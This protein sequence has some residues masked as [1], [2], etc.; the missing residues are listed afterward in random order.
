M[1]DVLTIEQY[2]SFTLAGE[3]YALAVENVREVLE[4]S[5][6]TPLPRVPA[7]MRGVINV[8]GSVVPVID[9]RLKM[10][11]SMTEKGIDTCVVVLDIPSTEGMATVGALVDSVQEVVEFD[12]ASVEPPPRMG[13]SVRA[14][15]L[16]GIGKRDERFVLILDIST[17]FKEG[18]LQSLTEGAAT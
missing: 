15:H 11:M 14:E 16:R 18:E 2:L 17:I 9:L 12:S 1:S 7:F 13:T 5:T 8:R 3:T 6:I 4:M 10:G